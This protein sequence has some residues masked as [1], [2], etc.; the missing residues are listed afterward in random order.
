MQLVIFSY[1]NKFYGIPS[2]NVE[3][4]TVEVEWTDVPKSP[5]W[6]LGLINL[7]GSIL[8][9]LNFGKLINRTSDVLETE[10]L[11][12]NNTI[13]VT[14]NDEE[15]KVALAVDKVLEVIDMDESEIQL[16]EFKDEVIQGV[17]TRNQR[18]INLV[19]L[20]ALLSI[21]MKTIE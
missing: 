21:N 13:I 17:Y 14:S 18:I 4:I 16:G 2:K 3:E 10:N 1:Q 9:L 12:Y 5:N 8:S 15:R 20:E 6:L 11:C 19:D 7:R